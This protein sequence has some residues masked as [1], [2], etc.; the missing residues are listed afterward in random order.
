MA[1]NSNSGNAISDIIDLLKSDLTEDLVPPVIP[2]N[3][4]TTVDTEEMAGYFRVVNPRNSS[5]YFIEYLLSVGRVELRPEGIALV[6]ILDGSVNLYTPVSQ[7]Q[8]C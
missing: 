1:I 3:V 4:D 6:G 8:I 7:S 2:Y 5:L